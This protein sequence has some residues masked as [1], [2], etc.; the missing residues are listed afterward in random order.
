MSSDDES[1]KGDDGSEEEVPEKPP[2]WIKTKFKQ[3]PPFI[4]KKFL[5][6]T[7]REYIPK[8]NIEPCTNYDEYQRRKEYAIEQ[9]EM[10]LS[11]NEDEKKKAYG[12]LYYPIKG[13]EYLARG[14][15]GVFGRIGNAKAPNRPW[16][17]FTLW[18]YR[19][20]KKLTWKERWLNFFNELIAIFMIVLPFFIWGLVYASYIK[21]R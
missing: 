12:N 21:N 9:K 2:K 18:D 5:G 1:E 19:Y 17:R 11:I 13:G 8:K 6:V 16:L 10:R 15:W 3:F 14:V 4:V 20:Q 7:Y